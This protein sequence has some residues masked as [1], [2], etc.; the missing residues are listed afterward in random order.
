MICSKMNFK[1]IV[2]RE[3]LFSLGLIV[4]N[5]AAKHKC[6]SKQRLKDLL[7][8]TKKKDNLHKVLT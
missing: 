8:L 3:V 6:K 1:Q 2:I 5:I 4:S 7:E